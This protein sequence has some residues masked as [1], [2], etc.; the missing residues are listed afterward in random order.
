MA[1]LDY[2]DDDNDDKDDDDNDNDDDKDNEE[3][4]TITHPKWFLILGSLHPLLL[5]LK[6]VSAVAHLPFTQNQN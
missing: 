5:L 3:K 6:D 2:D 1:F 4:E